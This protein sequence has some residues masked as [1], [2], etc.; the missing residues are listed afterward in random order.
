MTGNKSAYGVGGRHSEEAP[1][2]LK[3]TDILSLINHLD[4]HNGFLHVRTYQNFS[5]LQVC[6]VYH[7]R[8]TVPL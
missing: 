4:Y 3:V 2:P 7:D 1:R 5:K 6:A 8:S